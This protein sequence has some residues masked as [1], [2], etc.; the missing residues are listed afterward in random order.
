MAT[1]ASTASR[2]D[3][4]PSRARRRRR[5]S[6]LAARRA[7]SSSSS[8]VDAAVGGDASTI[9]REFVFVPYGDPAPR[10]RASLSCDGKVDGATL[11]LTHWT[12]NATPVALY[13]D[14]S[15]EIAL[16]L[17]RA[18]FDDAA[19][20]ARFDDAVVLN[21][22]YDVDGVLSV[23][24]C[25]DPTNALRHLEV[26]IAA[27][28]AGD[29]GEWAGD[30]DDGVKLACALDAFA[31][32]DAD[33]E[34]YAAALAAIRDGLLDDIDARED[35]WRRGVD[36][37]RASWKLLEDGVATVEVMEVDGARVAVAT[38]PA[39]APRLHSGESS[40]SSARFPCPVSIRPRSR[41]ARRSSRRLRLRLRFAAAFF[42]ALVQ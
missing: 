36:E 33:D 23:Y 5:A 18:R 24:A 19:T 22:H 12:N 11:D 2:V 13:A 38:A 16:N 40:S 37:M 41:G 15:T 20:Y 21:N 1:A 9:A 34:G 32:D 42:V 7:P 28:A 25:V 31:D 30:G 17:A 10:D 35:L 39:T 4:A 6:S 27:A 3:V 8:R 29:F 26:M 14:T